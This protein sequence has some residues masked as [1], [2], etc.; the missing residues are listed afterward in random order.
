MAH[1]PFWKKLGKEAIREIGAEAI[2]VWLWPPLAAGAT[3]FIGYWQG[4][5]LFYIVVGVAVV[6]AAFASGL[7]RFDEW[8]FR[9]RVQDKLNFEAGRVGHKS[10]E[11]GATSAI[12]LGFQLHNAATFPIE[13]DVQS[14]HTKLGANFPPNKPYVK[15]NFSIPPHGSGWFDDHMIEIR[16]SPKDNVVEGSIE[17]VINYGRTGRLKYTLAKHLQVF[18]GFNNRGAF[19][20]A[21]WMEIDPTRK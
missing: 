10:N 8:R 3:A 15:T 18:V 2:R 17:F 11:S 6:F 14:L 20:D 16:D 13:F 9:Q 4:I 12:C 7:L 21:N 1:Q 5:P 19:T